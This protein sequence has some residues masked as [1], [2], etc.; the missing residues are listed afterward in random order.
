M[1][2]REVDEDAPI[3]LLLT[4]EEAAQALSLGRSFMY[5]LVLRRKILSV[6]IGRYRRIPVAALESF[7]AQQ[8]QQE[9]V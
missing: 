5:D 7:V 2:K 9:G 6:K 1:R 4:M 8:I 3:K